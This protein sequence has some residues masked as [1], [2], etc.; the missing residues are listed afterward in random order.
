[1][2][3]LAFR[4]PAVHSSYEVSVEVRDEKKGGYSL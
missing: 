1:M 3:M 4:K 2:Q